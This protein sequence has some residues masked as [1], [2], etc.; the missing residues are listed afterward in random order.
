LK[1]DAEQAIPVWQM[2]SASL[3]TLERRAR[4]WIGKLRT[5]GIDARIVQGRSAAGGGSLPGETLPTWLVAIAVSSPNQLVAR[6]RAGQPPVIARIED[7][8]V[9]FD[10]RTILPRQ[11][12]AFLGA[13]LSAHMPET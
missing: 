8:L 10:P 13:V 5:K 7:D 2:M 4:R 3:D 11:E 1:G 12:K 9:C 6:L